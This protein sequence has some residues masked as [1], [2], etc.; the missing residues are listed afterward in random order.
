MSLSDFSLED[1]KKYVEENESEIDEPQKKSSSFD[2]DSLNFKILND[3]GPLS[4]RRTAPHFT[5]VN[6][7]GY[8]RYDLRAWKNDMTLPCKG[9]TFDQYEIEELIEFLNDY[10]FAEPSTTVIREFN[11]GQANAKFYGKLCELSVSEVK[12]VTWKKEI[13][14]IDWGY[15]K[16]VDFRKWTYDYSKCSKGLCVTFDELKTLKSILSSIK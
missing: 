2:T 3:F 12:D 16:K 1:I 4:D 6:W 15:G 5:L 7:G 13:N 9:T 14:I 10:S 11:G 8:K